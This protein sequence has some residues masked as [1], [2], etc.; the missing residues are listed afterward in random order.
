M[1]IKQVFPESLVSPSTYCKYFYR[2][3]QS[4]GDVENKAEGGALAVKNAGLLVRPCGARRVTWQSVAA[5]AITA[6]SC[7]PRMT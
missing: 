5:R 6:L 4:V 2:G 3:E 1:L 7:L